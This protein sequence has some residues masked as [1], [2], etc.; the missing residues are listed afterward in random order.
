MMLGF[1]TGSA[2]GTAGRSEE[3]AGLPTPALILVGECDHILPAVARQY[4][5]TLAGA[6]LVTLAE[7][8]HVI[9]FD[10]PEA[11]LEVIIQFL[12]EP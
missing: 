4:E 2:G 6:R 1:D 8:G 3:L 5:A 12:A 11:Y 9:Y 10:A 7:A